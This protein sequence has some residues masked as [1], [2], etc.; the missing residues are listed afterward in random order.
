MKINL[1]F[2]KNSQAGISTPFVKNIIKGVLSAVS[3]S[4]P[5]VSLSVALVTDKKIRT[6]NRIYRKKDKVTD[7]LSFPGQITGFKDFDGIDLGEVLIAINQAKRQAE[8]GGLSFRQ[9]FS[10][11]LVHGLLHLLG[12]DHE[13][14]KTALPMETLENKILKEI[15]GTTK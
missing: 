11:L 6:L 8:V 15:N 14:I 13:N 2:N 7:V 5:T 9:E 3:S 12:F 1:D 10:R 4:W